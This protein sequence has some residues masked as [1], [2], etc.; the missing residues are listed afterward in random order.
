MNRQLRRAALRTLKRNP[1]K[2]IQ[3]VRFA[4]RHRRAL[5]RATRLARQASKLATR[6]RSAADNPRVRSEASLAVSDLVATRRRV[7]ELGVA[8]ASRDGQIAAQLGAASAHARRAFQTAGTRSGRSR[9]LPLAL[10]A[11]G[12]AAIAIRA[13][14]GRRSSGD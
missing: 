12:A 13:A 6:M 14:G 8:S 5:T 3:V 7:R 10:G 2:A 4:V 9:K 1:R 11:L